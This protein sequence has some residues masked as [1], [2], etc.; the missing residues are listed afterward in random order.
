MILFSYTRKVNSY[1]VENVT[2]NKPNHQYCNHETLYIQNGV[3]PNP[4]TTSPHSTVI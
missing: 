4:K 2:F 1:K 3:N